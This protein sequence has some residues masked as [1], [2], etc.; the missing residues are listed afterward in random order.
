MHHAKSI[1]IPQYCITG[2][3]GKGKF[4]KQAKFTYWQKLKLV[5]KLWLDHVTF[6]I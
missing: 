4:G 3:F 5:A 1:T 6:N 2:I